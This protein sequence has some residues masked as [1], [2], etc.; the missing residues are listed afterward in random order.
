MN[1]STNSKIARAYQ[2]PFSSRNPAIRIVGFIE[3]FGTDHLSV[4]QKFQ[5]DYLN[6]INNIKK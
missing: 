3:S 2:A 1:T 4:K 6:T 5:F